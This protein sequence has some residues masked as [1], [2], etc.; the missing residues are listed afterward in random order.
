[1]D[2]SSTI[3][4]VLTAY[5]LPDLVGSVAPRKV[6]LAG[7][8]DQLLEPASEALINE[9]MKFPRAVY[10]FKKTSSNMKIVSSSGNL[11]SFVDWS[12]SK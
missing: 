10:D 2:F 1:M 6:L 3:A 9:E 12:F 11:S 4:G 7:L 8:K 5:D